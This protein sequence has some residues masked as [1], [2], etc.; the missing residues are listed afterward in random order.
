MPPLLLAFI[1]LLQQQQ[2]LAGSATDQQLAGATDDGMSAAALSDNL[3]STLVLVAGKTI[4]AIERQT[5]AADR[6]AGGATDKL[7]VTPANQLPANTAATSTRPAVLPTLDSF[8]ATTMAT[9]NQ[10]GPGAPRGMKSA[11]TLEA[12]S[13]T[14]APPRAAGVSVAAAAT[15]AAAI[16]A[17]IQASAAT[18]PTREQHTLPPR[19]AVGQMARINVAATIE[20]Q[21]GRA[22]IPSKTNKA[23]TPATPSATSTPCPTTE[24]LPA[25]TKRSESDKTNKIGQSVQRDD[26]KFNPDAALTHGY[27][28]ATE[29]WPTMTTANI[30]AGPS[31]PTISPALTSTATRIGG[32]AVPTPRLLG[33]GAANVGQ[34]LA[35]SLD[36]PSPSSS[37]GWPVKHAAVLEGDVILGGL[38]MVHSREDSITCGPIMPQGGIQALEAM[39]YTLDQVNKQQLLPNVTLGAHLLDDCDKDTYGLEMAVDFIKGWFAT[40]LRLTK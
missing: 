3:N 37:S 18:S 39:L 8:M 22:V 4:K 16:T 38:M 33:S 13:T 26:I 10:L 6:V 14:T 29:A 27:A 28:N 40:V 31:A 9:G 20:D 23:E 17:A 35:K 11:A 25:K 32:K 36:S 24:I 1:L 2:L 30:V 15:E 7:Q 34:I 21:I 5:K 19:P 12:N